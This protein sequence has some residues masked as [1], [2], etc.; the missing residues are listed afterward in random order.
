MSTKA[1]K[2]RLNKK[3]LKISSMHKISKMTD[4]EVAIL[5]K[6][7]NSALY[8]KEW[9]E[10]RKNVLSV[11]GYKCMKCGVCASNTIKINVDHIKPRKFYPELTFEFTNLQVLCSKCNKIKGNKNCNDY[12]PK[13]LYCYRPKE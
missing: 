2:I 7:S 6:T 9:K 12:R 13:P 10:L 1:L 11:Y 5:T 4:C 3:A 8:S